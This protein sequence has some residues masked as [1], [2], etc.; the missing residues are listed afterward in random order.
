MGFSAG[1]YVHVTKSWPRRRTSPIDYPADSPEDGCFAL[2]LLFLLL[3]S[4]E[5]MV[6]TLAATLEHEGNLRMKSHEMG[7]TWLLDDTETALLSHFFPPRKHT[8]Q[9]CLN[10]SEFCSHIQLNLILANTESNNFWSTGGKLLNV[11]GKDFLAFKRDHVGWLN[12]IGHFVA[13]GE[14]PRG[15]ADVLRGWDSKTGGTWKKVSSLWINPL[16][17][18]HFSFSKVHS[19]SHLDS[20]EITLHLISSSIVVCCQ[21]PSSCA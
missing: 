4:V 3:Y 21:S 15:T 9:S 10:H 20:S 8:F 5:L 14:P 19:W 18:Y 17:G 12:C 7:G 1:R 11:S 13:W 2:L 6:E 16:W